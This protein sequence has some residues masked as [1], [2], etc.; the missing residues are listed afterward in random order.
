MGIF[1]KTQDKPQTQ[2]GKTT[3]KAAQIDPTHYRV[4]INVPM[5]SDIMTAD[6]LLPIMRTMAYHMCA[7]K[8]DDKRTLYAVDYAM[9]DRMLIDGS[10]VRMFAISY[11]VTGT[12]FSYC[13][14]TVAK[15]IR[16]LKDWGGI[17]LVEVSVSYV[18]NLS[19]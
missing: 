13:E 4:T 10:I 2:N 15:L 5:Q 7:I 12:E 16:A 8:R 3:V 18:A 11:D 19:L 9:N 6:E 14:N 17:K 1:G